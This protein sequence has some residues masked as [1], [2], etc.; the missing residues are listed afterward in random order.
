MRYILKAER[1]EYSTGTGTGTGL[2]IE[3]ADVYNYS[4]V[5]EGRLMAH[6][7]LEHHK[8]NIGGVGNE[9]I[10]MGGMWYVRAQFNDVSRS[11]KHT[12][13][14]HLSHE[15]GGDLYPKWKREGFKLDTPDVSHCSMMEGVKDIMEVSKKLRTRLDASLE[16]GR[17]EVYSKHAEKFIIRGIQL[18]NKRFHRYGGATMANNLFW[19]ISDEVDKIMS[20]MEHVGQRYVLDYNKRKCSVKSWEV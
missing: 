14:F 5:H 15:V 10:A 11:F 1:Q 18:A 2:I 6:D 7:L 16:I 13:L 17:W 12:G 20:Q 8:L 3:G 4:P 19:N 9:L